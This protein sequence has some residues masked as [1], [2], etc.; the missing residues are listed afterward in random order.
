VHRRSDEVTCLT[1][2]D[3]APGRGEAQFGELGKIGKI[4]V[5]IVCQAAAPIRM[6]GRRNS[7]GFSNLEDRE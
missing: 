3:F 1:I 2:A 7:S 4:K 5:I 6:G